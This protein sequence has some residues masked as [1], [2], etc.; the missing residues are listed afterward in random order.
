MKY[1]TKN[2]NAS[3]LLPMHELGNF[4]NISVPPTLKF[5]ELPPPHTR[6]ENSIENGRL[7]TAKQHY[8]AIQG[9]STRDKQ[10]R[11]VRASDHQKRSGWHGSWGS[12]SI[13]KLQLE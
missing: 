13:I 1:L 8:K 10:V 7:N 5:S 2:L 11:E 6:R 9:N 4:E 12:V 3:R